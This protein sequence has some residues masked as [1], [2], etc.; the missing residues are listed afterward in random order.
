MQAQ[1]GTRKPRCFGPSDP[2]WLLT[3]RTKDSFSGFRADSAASAFVLQVRGI[4]FRALKKRGP[5]CKNHQMAQRIETP[6]LTLARFEMT[7][8]QDVFGC[9]TPAVTRFMAWDPPVS[10]DE[11]KSGCE[12]R[13]QSRDQIQF[14]I[15]RKDTGECLGIAGVEGL[16]EDLPELGIWMKEA[17]QSQGYGREAVEAVARWASGDLIPD[18]FLY[19][20]AVENVASRRIAEGLNG[21]VIATRSG[22]KYD[23]VVYKIPL[24][25][26]APIHVK[27]SD[28]ELAFDF[29][30][31]DGMGNAAFICRETGRIYWTSEWDKLEDDDELPE[32]LEDEQKYLP[33][34]DKRDMGHGKLLVLSF[35]REF[36]PGDYGEIR[37]IFS[38]EGAF[39]QFKA[40]LARRNA[41]DSWHRYEN[42]Q[43]ERA[44]R[45]WCEVNS[46]T[47]VD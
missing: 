36:L 19:P 42:L 16:I 20:V 2:C 14:V 43:T 8:A 23:S 4:A 1:R 24:Q 9:I 32:D 41:I 6:R 11:F 27:R 25:R 31:V 15:R 46:I 38:R 10:F 18:G 29:A 34:P 21:E 17:A 28:L 5:D 13:L 40:L 37:D 47:L 12:T 35:A 3:H 33:L 39:Q 7:D 26:P 45:E 44:M 30:D 22:A